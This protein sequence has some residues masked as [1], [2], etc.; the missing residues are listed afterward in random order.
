M[1]LQGIDNGPSSIMRS[2]PTDSVR[3]R[4]RG[5]G[6][7]RSRADDVNSI[8]LLFTLRVLGPQS[9]ND[10]VSSSTCVRVVH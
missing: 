5:R 6:G 9:K 1:L 4:I 3:M 7:G 8:L 2:W 10:E